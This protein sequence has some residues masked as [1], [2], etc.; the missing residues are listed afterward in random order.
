M[1][2]AAETPHPAHFIQVPPLTSSPTRITDLSA[3]SVGLGF[4]LGDLD[5]IATG[6]VAQ[7]DDLAIKV[8][9]SSSKLIQRKKLTTPASAPSTPLLIAP[10]ATGQ[11]PLRHQV[12]C[13]N[14]SFGL[15]TKARGCGSQ[16]EKSLG[17]KRK[18]A[19]EQGQRHWKGAGQE[20]ARE[21]SHTPGSL[22]KCEGV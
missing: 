14:P 19:R 17:V 9:A 13:P 1:A 16:E 18:E 10:Q 6:Q 5:A 3:L 22:R 11:D 2:K 15:A 21:S 7:K 8:K 20:E 4:G 12:K